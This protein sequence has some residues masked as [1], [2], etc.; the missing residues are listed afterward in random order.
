MDPSNKETN[1]FILKGGSPGTDPAHSQTREL[2]PGE[3]V[4]DGRYKV[5]YFVG[6]G[7]VGSVYSV[8]QVL[9]KKR[10]A[11][12]TL[13]P[14][15]ASD[16]TIRR[17]H[18][19][20]QA[21]G[22]LDHPNL[23]RAVDFGLID[24]NRPFIIMDFVE[25]QTLGGYLKKNGALSLKTALQIFIPVCQ[26]M[27][28]A[29]KQGVI[30]RDITPNNIVL[31]PSPSVKDEFIPRIIDFGIAKVASDDETA[32]TKVG[33]VFGT[34]LYMSPEQCL[35][36]KIDNRSDLYSLG[37]VFFESLTGSPPFR[38]ESALATMMQHRESRPHTLKEASLGQEF[39]EALERIVAMMLAKDPA[40]RYSNCADLAQDLLALQQGHPE[41]VR[42]NAPAL[43]PGL[44]V[45]RNFP[46][47]RII[48]A[49]MAV[50]IVAVVAFVWHYLSDEKPAPVVKV[51]ETVVVPEGKTA[52]EEQ[53]SNKAFATIKNG[54]R[55]YHVPARFNLG[56]FF[57]WENGQLQKVEAKSGVDFNVPADAKLMVNLGPQLYTSN[58]LDFSR[59]GKGE[60]SGLMII[61]LTSEAKNAVEDE[62]INSLFSINRT[63]Q[64][65]RLLVWDLGEMPADTVS[66]IEE[67]PK[68]HWLCLDEGVKD[69][70][71]LARLKNLR[72]LKVLS[73]E[74]VANVRD[75]I[76][77]LVKSHSLRRL[78]IINSKVT[79]DDLQQICRIRT[80]D[81]LDVKEN[82]LADRGVS[83]EQLWSALSELPDLERLSL[84]VS[85]MKGLPMK[86]F[87]IPEAPK[88]MKKLKTLVLNY[89]K[90]WPADFKMKLVN[91][92]A[93]YHIK[94]IVADQHALLPDSWF[95]P[96]KEDPAS[97]NLW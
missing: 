15:T 65:V 81:T 54:V 83:Q 53:F 40:D 14:G 37:C 57:W 49:S 78:A 90:D 87:V 27:D 23:V 25:G 43:M 69:G 92:Y 41:R 50:G 71:R 63:L 11:L 12:K 19:E 46:R 94:V 39:P 36:A 9:L 55:A 74:R 44:P 60:L 24:G 88:H 91:A 8:E 86:D 76:N 31:V 75:V 70:K 18:K 35:G 6:R 2:S 93:K 68:L 58:P 84:G 79:L 82:S 73:I 61:P 89:C 30:H 56:E 4:A 21:A 42:A 32:L 96:R 22:R 28:Y 20:A 67:L 3:L 47:R 97:E 51:P 48:I 52:I 26:A 95:D 5:Q 17:F 59:F 7:A 64:S 38:A 33:E 85:S 62:Q 10:F 13:I 77:Q 66:S 1:E 80:L 29:H 72:E 16:N 34:P 45:R